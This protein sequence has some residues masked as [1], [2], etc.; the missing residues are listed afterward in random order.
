MLGLRPTSSHLS[1]CNM[2]FETADDAS[3]VAS[4]HSNGRYSPAADRR[5][6]GRHRLTNV[7]KR[8]GEG[9]GSVITL[10]AEICAAGVRE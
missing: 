3:S 4:E 2:E 5:H 10:I 8:R 7:R 6:G 9:E 1:S